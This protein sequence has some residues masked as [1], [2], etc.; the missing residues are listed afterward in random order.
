MKLRLALIGV[1][2]SAALRSCGAPPPMVDGKA[3]AFRDSVGVNTHLGY[4]AT[5]YSNAAR[6][7]A[8]LRLL[9]ITHVR[10]SA[11]REG[12]RTLPRYA[13]LAQGGV[14][15]DLFVNRNLDEQLSRVERLLARAPTGVQSLEGPNEANHEPFGE[16]A[17]SGRRA[18]QAYQARLY[19][20]VRASPELAQLPVYNLT[21]WPPL[22]G[23]AD[24]GNFHVYPAHD[25]KIADVLSWQRRLAEAVQPRGSAVVCTETG[26]PTGGRGALTEQQQAESETI[27]L[28]ENFRARVAQTFLYELYD[29]QGGAPSAQSDREGRWGLFRFDGTP[30]PAAFAVGRLMEVLAPTPGAAAVSGRAPFAVRGPHLRS[31]R[32]RRR[33]GVQVTLVWRG[34]AGA[35]AA[36]VE[37]TTLGP[38]AEMLNLATGEARRLGPGRNAV[39][40]AASPLAFIPAPSGTLLTKRSSSAQAAL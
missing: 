14:K 35:R 17:R 31:L 13:A 4:E 38:T 28:L 12:E 15:L 34:D 32:L 24:A 21:Y 33:D 40:L 7:L 9:G 18:A 8:A 10:D 29:E 20:G 5:P 2:V 23:L 39:I 27:L 16:G 19:R 22:A 11:L 30:K 1:L 3:D 6:T 26:L 25:Q 37:V 36:P